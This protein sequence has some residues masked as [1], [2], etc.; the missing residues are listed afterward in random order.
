MIESPNLEK[1]KQHKTDNPNAMGCILLAPK[2]HKNG[3]DEIIQ[4]LEYLNQR[5]GENL[6]FYCAGFGAYWNEEIAPDMEI[7][8]ISLLHNSNRIPWAF[9]QNFFAKF[10]T[11][12]ENETNWKYSGGTEIIV[13]DKNLEFRNCIVFKID[14][15]IS[16]KIIRSPN[17]IIEALIQ[18]SK[19][20]KSNTL[21]SLKGIGIIAIDEALKAFL[22]FLPKSVENI[23]NI[24]QKGKHYTLIDLK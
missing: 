15:M 23:W 18:Q 12:L 21:I 11:E 8:N 7:L 4:R 16:D 9:S 24:W 19:K 17:D 6:H 13:L 20:G 3:F 14:E 5:S 2:F 22:G 1:V 10:V